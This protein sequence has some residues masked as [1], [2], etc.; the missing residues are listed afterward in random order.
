MSWFSQV[1][2]QADPADMR[3][4]RALARMHDNPYEQ[5]QQLWKLFDRPPG[6]QRPFL[7][8]HQLQDV[9]ARPDTG[10]ASGIEQPTK[11]SGRRGQIHFWL[12]SSDKPAVRE[13]GWFIRSKPYRP[14]FRPGQHLAFELRINPSVKRLGSNGKSQRYDPIALALMALPEKQRAAERQ[15]WIHQE[16]APWLAARG[17]TYGFELDV[18]RTAVLRY[19]PLRFTGGKSGREI[20]LSVAD[21]RGVLQV[22]DPV[23]FGQ[24]AVQ[25]VGHARG[26]GCGALLL[27][28]V[29]GT[30]RSQAEEEEE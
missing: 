20:R 24:A 22:V 26:F 30:G 28:P 14:A 15:R 19:E 12:I 2:Y 3:S 13:V 17:D 6:S 5:H 7:F 10:W 29:R 1:R 9:P 18:D 11:P 27:K 23:R 8:H 25:G 16:L 21:F 4:W